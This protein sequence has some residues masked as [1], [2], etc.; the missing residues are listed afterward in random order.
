MLTTDSLDTNFE[1]AGS[2][3]NPQLSSS[4]C[5][6]ESAPLSPLYD[7][8]N[9]SPV[10]NLNCSNFNQEKCKL[11]TQAINYIFPPLNYP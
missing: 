10:E 2:S 9:C 8:Y 5:M 4:S 11:V 6:L 7:T 3:P 1:C